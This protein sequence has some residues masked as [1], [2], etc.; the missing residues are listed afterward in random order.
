MNE[1]EI[2][3]FEPVDLEIEP[4]S[5]EGYVLDIGGGGEGIIGRLPSLH[6]IS[7]DRREDELIEAPDGPLKIV[8]DARDLK[9]TDSSFSVVTAFFSFIYFKTEADIQAAL[10]EA[11]RVLKPG[12]SLRLWDV[13]FESLPDTDQPLFAVRLR[14]KLN[15]EMC[16]TAYGCPWPNERR[17]HQFYKRITERSGFK[18]DS[19]VSLGPVFHSTF[20]KH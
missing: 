19:T 4:F 9:F 15:E 5:S 8:M 13:N 7:I 14:C 16:E 6:V 17:D 3:F 12:G 18:H 11:H 1:N 2:Y 20:V 10:S